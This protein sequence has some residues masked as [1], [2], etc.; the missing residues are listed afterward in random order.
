MSIQIQVRRGTA[1][2]WTSANPLLAQGE[3]GLE[4]DTLKFKFGDG[5]TTWT[6]LSYSVTGLTNPMTTSQDIIVGGSGGAATRLA[7]GADGTV[8]TLVSGNIVW[9]A[10]VAA[11]ISALT[12]DVAA[13]GSGSV[14]AT[15]A[16]VNANVGSFT[17]ANITVNAKGLITAAANGSGGGGGTPGGSS[18]QVQYNNAGS[19]GGFGSTAG[20]AFQVEGNTVFGGQGL[21]LQ[22][23]NLGSIGEGD[24]VNYC[25]GGVD[26]AGFCFYSVADGTAVGTPIARLTGNSSASGSTP[27]TSFSLN[28]PRAGATF[29]LSAYD[30]Q[31]INGITRLNFISVTVDGGGYNA[32][33][34]QAVSG[35][36]TH[37]I[38]GGG[39]LGFTSGSG[40]LLSL[41]ADVGISRAAAN[42]LN[43][44]N[45]ALSDSS[46]TVQLGVV[47]LQAAQSTIGGATSGNMVCSQPFQGASYKKVVINLAALLGNASYT[48]PVAFAIKPD[49]FIG[50]AAAS[51]SVSVSTTAITVT[52]ATSTGVI[53]LEGY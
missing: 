44:G 22:W 47:N 29:G 50:G 53:I 3:I 23:N 42:T 49:Y 19:F 8:L 15:L 41:P 33:V 40:G 18:G 5:A 6:T 39:M 9:Q 2:A 28:E 12:G 30:N 46:A 36:W 32:D 51:A 38:T 45:G 1:A 11:G 52:G 25:G 43:I 27:L 16:T 4:T 17:N 24:F 26:N 7:K 10:P 13:S 37:N 14:A 35:G 21:S 20:G 34:W 48:F 31:G